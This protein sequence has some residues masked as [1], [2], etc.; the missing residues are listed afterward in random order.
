MGR[1][2]ALVLGAALVILVAIL[3]AMVLFPR[4]DPTLSAGDAF[5]TALVLM[6]GGTYADLFPPFH[7]LSNALRFFS[8]SSADGDSITPALNLA[9]G[10]PVRGGRLANLNLQLG[11]RRDRIRPPAVSQRGHAERSGLVDR[12]G[13]HLYWVPNT[14]ASV[15]Y[16]PFVRLHWR[17][18]RTVPSV[19]RI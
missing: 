14:G 4:S 2:T 9:D 19:S 18:S 15:S 11:S 13:R 17:R 3:V 6:T 16:S 10:Q 7:H 1:S 8:V 5:F 12:F